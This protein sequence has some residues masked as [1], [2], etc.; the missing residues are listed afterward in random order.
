MSA[1]ILLLDIETAPAKVLTW[2]M[3][4]VNHTIDQIVEDDYVLMWAAKWLDKNETMYDAVKFCSSPSNYSEK[5]E[6]SIMKSLWNLLDEADMVIA[7]NGKNFDIRWINGC[8]I[9]H[10]IPPPS[11]FSVIDTKVESSRAARYLSHKLEYLAK[12]Y[13]LKNLKMSPGGLILWKKCM[14]GDKEAWSKMIKYCKQDIAVLED[15]YK[16]LRPYMQLHPNL[17]LFHDRSERVCPACESKK[18]NKKGFFYT[19][20][21]IY[22][23]YRCLNCGKNIRDTKRISG[24]DIVGI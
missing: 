18:L 21:G 6:K 8:F 22:Q 19:R 16:V 2:N 15:V 23:R 24:T 1:K 4:K 3:Y 14:A 10:R 7:H 13:K 11:P 5:G 20:T 17:A 9:K 12:K